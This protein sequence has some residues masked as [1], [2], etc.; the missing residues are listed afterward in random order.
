[1]KYPI[2][3]FFRHEKYGYIDSYFTENKELLNF[4]VDIISTSV[5]LVE[6]FDSSKRHLL[7][8][9]GPID[10]EYH[11]E[12]L[13][14]LPGKLCGR[15]VHYLEL[16]NIHQFNYS[17][18]YCFINN[19]IEDRV[20]TRPTFSAFTTTYNSYEKIDRAYNS[21]K[22][23]TMKCWEWVIVDDS[24]DDAHFQ[25][26]REKFKQDSRI[27]LYRKSENSGNIGNVKN[28]AVSLSRGKYV[29]ELDHDDEIVCDL[30]E[31]ATNV[32]EEDPEVG[33]VYADFINV[34]ENG[35][36]FHYGDFLC[37]GYAGYYCQK[38]KGRWANVYMTPNI[39]NI[40][41]SHLVCCPNHPRIWR[42][43]TLN[44]IGNY[45]EF[46][47]ICDDY[48]ILLRTA[49]NT[50]MA[51]IHKLGYIQYMNE[52]NN[53][54]SLIRNSEI[55]RIGPQFIFPQFY[56]KY[57]VHKAMKEKDAYENEAYIH[58]HSKIW[59]RDETTY[60]YKFCNKIVNPDYDLQVC[61]IGFQNLLSNMEKIKTFQTSVERTDIIVLDNTMNMYELCA[62]LDKL[63]SA[64]D[65]VKCYTLSETTNQ[66]LKRYFHLLYRSC[67]N[68]LVIE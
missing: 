23:Q 40:T 18:N 34:Y 68:V 44:Q 61:V 29:L 19:A 5:R 8:T 43:E 55:N 10:S 13:N 62:K 32:F 17:I 48:E 33:F 12:V 6:L 21:L 52:N 64:F 37:K 31:N 67:E 27:R 7:I 47:P 51:K 53:N 50:K 20:K 42:R 36:N 9:F 60:E 45:S 26:M 56:E 65:K 28:E 57:E 49:C 39:N 3:F 46:L 25:F 24:P 30:F 22:E 66:Q 63:G 1:M 15:W 2:I 41:L 58:N 4:T 11:K 14:I 54:F 38:Y 59:K 16:P 35:N